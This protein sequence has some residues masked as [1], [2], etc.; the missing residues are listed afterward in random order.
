VVAS[1]LYIGTSST[2][3]QSHIHKVYIHTYI[4]TRTTRGHVIWPFMELSRLAMFSIDI[5][6]S[7]MF[8]LTSDY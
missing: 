7:M 1:P 4:H 2:H 6:M 5:M 8:R 3:K